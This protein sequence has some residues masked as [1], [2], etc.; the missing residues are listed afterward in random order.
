[1]QTAELE[2]F[3]H[4]ATHLPALLK[5]LHAYI[6]PLACVYIAARIIATRTHHTF[7]FSNGTR[8]ADGDELGVVIE[9]RQLFDVLLLRSE[10]DLGGGDVPD[11]QVAR[12]SVDDVAE[13]AGLKC[14]SWWAHVGKERRR[15]DRSSDEQFY[16]MSM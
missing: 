4:G 6:G 2:L 16:V 11:Q 13:V 3:G 10:Q 9:E 5:Y 12:L 7:V 15:F 14:G 8:L 1:M